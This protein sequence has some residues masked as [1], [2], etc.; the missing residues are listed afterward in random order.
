MVWPPRTSPVVYRRMSR[1]VLALLALACVA[2]TVHAAATNDLLGAFHEHTEAAAAPFLRVR[3][4]KAWGESHPALLTAIPHTVDVP[5]TVPPHG[6]L[7]VGVA[8]LDRYFGEDLVPLAAPTRF[9][10]T[11]LSSAGE[12]IVVERTL[13]IHDRPEQRRWFPVRADLSR[14]AGE[15][16]T[17]RFRVTLAS[18]PEK[19]GRT[20]ALWGRPSLVDPTA[21][22]PNLLFVT[23][24]ALRADHLG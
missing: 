9:T 18:D 16:G 15:S 17:L 20:F 14:F 12:T 1:R 11:F 23:I 4:V 19:N 24:D 22:K 8:M 7:R 10:V 3:S 21:A 6:R 2:A 5:V 13:D